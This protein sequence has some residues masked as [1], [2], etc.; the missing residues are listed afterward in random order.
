MSERYRLDEKASMGPDGEEKQ[1]SS[2]LPT[3][4]KPSPPVKTALHPAF[5]IATWIFFSSTVILFNK[6]ILGTKSNFPFPISLTAW[7]LA[8]ATFVTQGMARFTDMLDSRRSV[9]MTTQIYIRKIVPIGVMFSLSLICSNQAYLYLSVSFIQMLK[10]TMPIAVL[11]TTWVLGVAPPSLQ[12]LGNVSLIVAGVIIASIGEIQFN[13]TGFFF[14]ACGIIFEAVRLVMVQQILSGNDF[15]MDPL[16]SLYYF[17]PVCAVMNAAVAFALEVP[18]ITTLQLAN[19]GY[20]TFVANAA[21]AFLLNVAVV[22]L[23]GKTSSLVMTLSGVL[24]DILLVAASMAI[25]LDP[26]TLLQAVGYSIALAG[27][28]YYKLGSEKTRELLGNLQ[29]RVAAR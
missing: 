1:P 6:W 18:R 16:V 15:K 3:T 25:F 12:K 24:K 4:E 19:V 20:P 9:A 8:F 22:F 26:V 14:Q 13:M 10:A 21:C 17:A 27:L 5:Y 23:I 2:I 11:L 29:A 28:V 7:H